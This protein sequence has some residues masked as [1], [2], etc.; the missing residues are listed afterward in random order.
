M[1]EAGRRTVVIRGQVVDRYSPRRSIAEASPGE[2]HSRAE[3]SQAGR[4]AH[5]QSPDQRLNGDAARRNRSASRPRPASRRR[6]SY[7]APRARPD[8]IALWA[9]L[10]GV[11]LLLAA[12][13]GSH[14]AMLAHVVAR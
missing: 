1:A 3:S 14:A 5:R 4:R 12:A 9:V 8:R 10:L 2:R 13:T 7:D 6:P 11:V